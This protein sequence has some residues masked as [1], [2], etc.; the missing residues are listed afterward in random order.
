MSFFK[1]FSDSV[2]N[3]IHHDNA[4]IGPVRINRIAEK[5]GD[6]VAGERGRKFGKKIDYYTKDVTISF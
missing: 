2:F 4:Q 3:P 5:V 1:S 6:L